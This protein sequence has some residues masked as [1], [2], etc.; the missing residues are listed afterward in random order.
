M[1]CSDCKYFK[2][3]KCKLKPEAEYFV[4]ENFDCF[5]LASG[6][7][8]NSSKQ[9]APPG[10]PKGTGSLWERIACI[11]FF[12]GISGTIT[13]L[14]MAASSCNQRGNADE[15]M[16]GLILLLMALP[17]FASMALVGGV[18]WLVEWKRLRRY[19]N[20]FGKRASSSVDS[21][22]EKP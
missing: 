3:E 15:I 11:F 22:S 8:A 1:K 13:V 21:R 10:V 18:W 7:E 16:P 4:A 12:I 17:V 2:T 6:R 19:R 14:G 9:V 20:S 5:E